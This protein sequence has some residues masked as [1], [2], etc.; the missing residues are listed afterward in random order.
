MLIKEREQKGKSVVISEDTV[1][2]ADKNGDGD[3]KGPTRGQ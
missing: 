1:D 2:A 3:A